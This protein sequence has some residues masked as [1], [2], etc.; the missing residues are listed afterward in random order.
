MATRDAFSSRPRFPV[1]YLFFLVCLVLLARWQLDSRASDSI[2]VG[3]ELA[4]T[5]ADVAAICGLF[6]ALLASGVLPRSWLRKAAA[7]AIGTVAILACFT[8][9]LHFDFFR[10]P[11][12]LGNLRNAGDL[13]AVRSSVAAV[14]R[15][16][17]V[18]LLIAA[19][20]A[21][22]VVAVARSEPPLRPRA[23]SLL[24]AGFLA[25]AAACYELSIALRG[26][27]RPLPT[28]SNV[29]AGLAGDLMPD[30]RDGGKLDPALLSQ[31]ALLEDVPPEPPSRSL[32]SVQYPLLRRRTL[33]GREERLRA[34]GVDPEALL[35]KGGHPN[36]VI[37]VE[38]SLR[39]SEVGAYGLADAVTPTIDGLARNGL[40]VER[41]YAS[42]WQSVKA[43][44]AIECSSPPA[45][46]V[47]DYVRDGI[48][49]NVR[50][51][52]EIL[53]GAGYA[54]RWFAG[55]DGHFDSEAEFMHDHG[56]QKI[57]DGPFLHWEDRFNTGVS[58]RRLFAAAADELACTLEP[59]L[60]IVSTASGHHPFKIPEGTV[61]A[62]P[63]DFAGSYGD[64]R[65]ASSYA[66]SAIASFLE[67]A[68][69]QPWFAKT[70]FILTGD[71]GT[72]DFPEREDQ[73]RR[74]GPL[75]DDVKHELFFRVPLIIYAPGLVRPG[76]LRGPASHLDVLPT[77]LDLVGIEAEGA[78]FGASLFEPPAPRRLLLSG[79]DGIHAVQ[80]EVRCWGR[81][82]WRCVRSDDPRLYGTRPPIPTEAPE[83]A[84]WA[85]RISRL[86]D[87]LIRTNRSAP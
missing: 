50:C 37:I 73:A 75:S 83:L 60:A 38:E 7:A 85:A 11:V 45:P 6:A 65:R 71:H 42:S 5:A 23:S 46:G 9:Q 81:A 86:A 57:I 32:F 52:P 20:L 47:D 41:F 36:V 79:L 76:K 1:L 49:S 16:S 64:L 12:H 2:T 51:L 39:A 4:G 84:S 62:R 35:A 40:L 61:G 58:D 54:T 14:G 8:N 87:L 63:R 77:V 17:D 18:I 21:L 3:V 72:Y 22:L 66:D 30:L 44:F 53:R 67:Q 74:G 13:L 26:G 28:E 19:P 33:E 27:P 82:A 25:A 78:F 15:P 59:F 34:A 80:G 31:A 29:F 10:M 24:A 68:R 70:V 43:S 55:F 56:I 48:K 69:G